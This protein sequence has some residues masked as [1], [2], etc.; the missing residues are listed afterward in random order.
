[1]KTYSTFRQIKAIAKNAFLVLKT[2]SLLKRGTPLLWP[3][4]RAYTEWVLESKNQSEAEL[5]MSLTGIDQTGIQKIIAETDLEPRA[6]LQYALVRIIKPRLVVETG[7]NRGLSSAAILTAM[8]RN[9]IGEL[10]SIDLPTETRLTDGTIYKN[11][12]EIGKLVPQEIRRRW[13]L[14]L[15]DAKTELPK[16]LDEIKTIDIFLHDSL[17][18]EEHMMWEFQ[19]AWPYIRD[20]GLLLSDDIGVS[21]LKFVKKTKEKNW[22]CSGSYSTKLG[23][24]AK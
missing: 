7:V 8:E 12:T 6:R 13:H 16:L 1:M 17:H 23:A 22:G 15:G 5:I 20:G 18:T 3:I 24:I 4:Q 14:I 2:P 21:F 19:T 10:Y 9:Q 11:T